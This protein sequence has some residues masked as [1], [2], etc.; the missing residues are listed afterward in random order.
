MGDKLVIVKS[1]RHSFDDTA[2]EDIM[3]KNAEFSE[4]KACP[5]CDGA[6]EVDGGTAQL[7][8]KKPCPK[9]S[10]NGMKRKDK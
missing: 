1:T 8:Y 3:P 5:T 4:T 6:G 2:P 9:C 7:K 10:G